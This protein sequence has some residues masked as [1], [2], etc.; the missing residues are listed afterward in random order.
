MARMV[1][2][3]A[4]PKDPEAF[5]RHYFEVHIPLA[6]TLPGLIKYEVSRG[7]VKSLSA[8]PSP[9][10]VGTLYFDDMAAI[11]KAFVSS[12]GQ[13]CA[14]DRKIFAPHDNDFQMYLFDSR[15]M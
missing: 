4:T 7:T 12:V 9:Y 15:E 5:D 8:N 3:Y 2:I 1:V 10:L 11:N 13:A 14:A 6:K